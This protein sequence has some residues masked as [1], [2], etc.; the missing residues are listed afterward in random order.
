MSLNDTPVYLSDDSP[1]HHTAGHLSV[2]EVVVQVLIGQ[3]IAITC[4]IYTWNGYTN[5][6]FKLFVIIGALRKCLVF[7]KHI[8]PFFHTDKLLLNDYIGWG[9]GWEY[10]N[11][12][13][14]S[15]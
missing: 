4:G 10:L 2:L 1:G 8:K 13:M 14:L 3:N 6:F 12:K 11:K 7:E 5:Y 9:G 15:L